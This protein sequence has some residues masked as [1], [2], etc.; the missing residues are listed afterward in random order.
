MNAS[1][2]RKE[3][4]RAGDAQLPQE[5]RRSFQRLKLLGQKGPLLLLDQCPRAPQGP[6]RDDGFYMFPPIWGGEVS[7]LPGEISS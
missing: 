7:K 1:K 4:R 6:H 5:L 2:R 3:L